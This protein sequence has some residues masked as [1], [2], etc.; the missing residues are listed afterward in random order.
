MGNTVGSRGVLTERQREIIIGT[1]LG[2][3]CLEKN[4]KYTRL[5]IDHYNKQKEYIFWL[6]RELSPFSLKPRIINEVDKRNGKTYSRWHFSTKSLPIFTEF[7]ELFYVGKRKIVP[8][9]LD[10][11]ITPLS[12]AIWYMDDGFRRK[13]S[14]GFYLCTSSYTAKEHKILQE[15]LYKRFMISTKIHHQRQYMRT[16][17]PSASAESFNKLVKPYVL[18]DLNYKLL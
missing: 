2:D 10:E 16:F 12:L 18:P 14:K 6:F 17:I 3:A 8:S 1:L 13:D 15:V 9:T 4:G 11:F 7:Q 5:R